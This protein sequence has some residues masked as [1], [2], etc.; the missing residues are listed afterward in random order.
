MK[1]RTARKK[2]KRSGFVQ[3]TL[4]AFTCVALALCAAS[5]TYGLFLR[6][7][8]DSGEASKF[9]IEILNGTGKKGLAN[10]VSDRLRNMGI[11]VLKVDNAPDFS[12]AKSVL[13]ARNRNPQ[14][15][16]LGKLLNCGNIIE[17]LKDDSMVDATLILGDDY[18]TLNIG[19]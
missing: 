13:I 7:S 1:R 19:L 18:K 9:R 15:E 10:E 4:I 5:V 17:Q 11:D 16:T 14:I 6:H 8:G 2:K 12:Y 3:K